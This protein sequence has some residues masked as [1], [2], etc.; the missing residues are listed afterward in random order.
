LRAWAELAMYRSEK[1]FLMQMET[2]KTRD[3]R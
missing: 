1:G 3:Y 2:W